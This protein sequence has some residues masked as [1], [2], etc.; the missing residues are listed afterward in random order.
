MTSNRKVP[1]VI[2]EADWSFYLSLSVSVVK[3]YFEWVEAFSGYYIIVVGSPCT[4]GTAY[5][6]HT[7]RYYHT[8]YLETVLQTIKLKLL[9]SCL[10]GGCSIHI[11]MSKG[12]GNYLISKGPLLE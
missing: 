1:V 3:G 10:K 5:C 6:T 8:F 11:M 2:K 4:Y 7:G 9:I 12:S